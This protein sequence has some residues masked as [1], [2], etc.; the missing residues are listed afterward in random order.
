MQQK[1]YAQAVEAFKNGLRNNP[2]DEET[3]YNY[4][5]AK[6]LLEKEQQLIAEELKN[7]G[8]PENI[9]QKISIDLLI[10]NF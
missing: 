3:R 4:A 7:S 6:E 1:D 9:T 2:T 8:K 10:Q 5:L